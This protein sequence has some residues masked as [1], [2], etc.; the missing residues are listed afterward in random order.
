M[1]LVMNSI[2]MNKV[3]HRFTELMGGLFR[4][5]KSLLSVTDGRFPRARAQPPRRQ[6]RAPVGSLARAVPAGVAVF[7]CK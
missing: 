4:V 2:K 5:D 7:H 6:I 3:F 1:N